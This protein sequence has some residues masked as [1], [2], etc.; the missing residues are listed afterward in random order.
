[1]VVSTVQASVALCVVHPT[2][3]QTAPALEPIIPSGCVQPDGMGSTAIE[4]GTAHASN[5]SAVDARTF[6]PKGCVQRE[7]L[8]EMP[9]MPK[10]KMRCA[11]NRLAGIGRPAG[12]WPK[13]PKFTGYATAVHGW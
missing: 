12:K 1:V 13:M 5:G 6:C 11:F 7:G 10:M 3:G 9:K 8:R 4:E 2:V